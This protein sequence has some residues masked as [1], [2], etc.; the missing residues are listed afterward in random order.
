MSI[1]IVCTSGPI[2]A[3]AIEHAV[4]LSKMLRFSKN[5]R[6]PA[7]DPDVPVCPRH[8]P[9][10]AATLAQPPDGIPHTVSIEMDMKHNVLS[11]LLPDR[12]HV[13]TNRSIYRDERPD[14]NSWQQRRSVRRNLPAM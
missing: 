1:R 2:H 3:N 12:I 5:P 11:S 13:S 4:Q 14:L 7:L 8:L 9:A 6:M 10:E